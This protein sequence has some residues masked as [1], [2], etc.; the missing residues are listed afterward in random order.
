[1]R[2]FRSDGVRVATLYTAVFGMAVIVLGAMALLAARS[3]LKHQ[4]DVRIQ[5]EALALA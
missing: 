2:L 1:M 4:L 3:A 5:A